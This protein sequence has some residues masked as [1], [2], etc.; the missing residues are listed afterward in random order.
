[1]RRVRLAL[2]AVL[3]MGVGCQS[4]SQHR[5]SSVVDYLYPDSRNVQVSSEV[6][7]LTLPL[8]VGV[9]FTPVTG[10]GPVE[11]SEVQKTELLQS[12]SRNFRDL[13]FV[14]SI[15]IVPSAYLRPGGSFENLQ[16]LKRMF[17]I[18]VIALVSYDQTRFTDEGWASI[19]YWTLVGAYVVPGEKNATHTLLDTVVYDID[20]RKMLFRAPGTSSVKSS[21]TPINLQEQ[22]RKDA[23]EGFELASS[24]LVTNLTSELEVFRQRIKKAPEEVQIAKREGYQGSGSGGWF[25]L[26]LAFAGLA[27]ARRT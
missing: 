17:D 27:A 24:D 18:D 8:K 21:A 2:V 10:Y 14:R 12:V 16:Q 3:L 15:E 6:P 7:R 20:S 19:A 25:L 23:A 26:L 13:E 5:N 22:T 11:L 1:M 9:A 4:A